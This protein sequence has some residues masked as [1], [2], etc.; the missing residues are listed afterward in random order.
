MAMLQDE[1]AVKD[2][3]ISDPT[4]RDKFDVKIEPVEPSALPNKLAKRGY[5]VTITAKEGLPVGRFHAWLTLNTSL[6][7]AAKLEIPI[8]G[9]VVGDISV[10]GISGW[11]EEQGVLNIGSVKSSEGGQGKV[12]LV[13]RGAGAGNIKFE[14]KS[15][16]PDDLKVTLGEPKKLKET[17]VHV[18]VTIEI[19]RG[20]RPM[21]HLDTVQG[22]AARIVFSTSHPKIK[23]LSLSVRF[24]VER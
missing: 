11:N 4:I 23:E 24:A 14:V 9:Q 3:Q 5:R 10:S 16:E 22:D 8:S 21:V 13:V 2:P 20:T 15:K 19:P 1:L 17:L 12:N 6:P 7:D 18:P